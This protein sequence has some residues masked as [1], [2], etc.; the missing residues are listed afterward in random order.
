MPLPSR[1]TLTPNRHPQAGARPCAQGEGL[2]V[3]LRKH[4]RPRLTRNSDNQF[5]R[6]GEP[7]P[8]NRHPEGTRPV[9][10]G[11]GE[12]RSSKPGFRQ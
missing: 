11:E 5:R 7:S 2:F 8:P 12:P 9:G 4:Q 10:P 6:R 3:A 1:E